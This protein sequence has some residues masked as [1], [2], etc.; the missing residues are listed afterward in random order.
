MTFPAP[1]HDEDLSIDVTPTEK[2]CFIGNF[3][4]ALPHNEFGEVDSSAYR[5]FERI[6]RAIE[7]G[8]SINFEN[9]AKMRPLPVGLAGQSTPSEVAKF[10]GPMAGAATESLG[11]DPRSINMPP[12]PGIFSDCTAAEMMELYWM[13]LLRDVPLEQ[14]GANA[15]VGLAVNELTARVNQA[16][17]NDHA[18]GAFCLVRDLPAAAGALDV[19]RETLFRCGLRDEEFGPL[20]SQFF[21]RDIPYGAQTINQNIRF[22]K[23][24][25]D[26][27]TSYEDWFRTQ[28]TGLDAHGRDYGNDN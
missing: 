12:S 13:A 21:L 10:V 22:Y 20:V 15:M 19:R 17:A 4:K 1:N 7:G 25:R 27:L 8:T 18:D 14:F 26:Y 5:N 11:L 23:E 6:C 16:L 9:V 3:H 28:E 2:A 24:K